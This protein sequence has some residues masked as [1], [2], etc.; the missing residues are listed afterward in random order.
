VTDI[1]DLGEKKKGKRKR[2]KKIKEREKEGKKIPVG[3]ECQLPYKA[4]PYLGLFS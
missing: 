3:G 4:T 2:R 1:T